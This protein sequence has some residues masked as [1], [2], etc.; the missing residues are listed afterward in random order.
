LGRT[1]VPSNYSCTGG[2]AKIDCPGDTICGS[3][4]CSSPIAQSNLNAQIG[5]HS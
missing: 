3:G 1:C 4:T 5:Q 2:T